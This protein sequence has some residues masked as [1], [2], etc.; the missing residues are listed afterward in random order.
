MCV[1]SCT[2][3]ILHW[4][5]LKLPNAMWCEW[6]KFNANEMNSIHECEL[7]YDKQQP[8]PLPLQPPPAPQQCVLFWLE[9]HSYDWRRRILYNNMTQ[10]SEL[11]NNVNWSIEITLAVIKI[12]A[13]HGNSSVNYMKTWKR[14]PTKLKLVYLCAGGGGCATVIV[15]FWDR[16]KKLMS[17]TH[18]YGTA[19]DNCSQ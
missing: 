7:Q 6:D 5:M 11:T 2:D 1:F 17:K 14:M 4:W 15:R 13:Y 10:R 3:W 18:N 19:H 12:K 8:P 9:F 16:N